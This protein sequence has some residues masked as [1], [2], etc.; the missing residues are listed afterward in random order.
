MSGCIC[1]GNWR[2]IINESAPLI[3]Q[4]YNDNNGAVHRFVGVLH[5]VDDYYYCMV[6][7]TGKW[8]LL[9]CVGSIEGH[10]YTK[11][12]NGALTCTTPESSDA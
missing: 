1:E 7:M 5:A 4:L 11:V 12:V 6:S 3:D 10:E 8:K 2:D 9:S